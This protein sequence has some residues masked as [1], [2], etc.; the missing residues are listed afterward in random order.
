[1]RR[2]FVAAAVWAAI[3]P[4]VVYAA[5]SAGDRETARG[6]LQDADKKFAAQ[7]YRSAL[8]GYE[9][10]HAI[11]NLPSTGY[12]VAKTRAAL[13]LLVEARDMALEVTRIPAKSSEPPAFARARESAAKLADD[14]SRRV[15]SLEITLRGGPESGDVQL[16]FDGESIPVATLGSPRKTNPGHHTVTAAASGFRS[17]SAEVDVAESENKS[18]QLELTAEAKAGGEAVAAPGDAN[19][20][21]SNPPEEPKH[22]FSPLVWAGFGVGAA[23]IV[24]GSTFGI[25]HLTKTAKVKDDYCH[26]GD[27]CRDGFQSERDT[28]KTYATVA[29][30]G[31]AVGLVGVAVGVVGIFTSKPHTEETAAVAPR[32][33]ITP[34]IGPGS[35]AV[36]G[37]F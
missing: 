33:R 19:T 4:T 27:A 7:D 37:T 3:A 28:A 8:Q 29:N 25:L 36:H 31:F 5:P 21:P 20:P 16:T 1:V 12:A 26:G 15:P 9:A 18:V 11:M 24:V 35:V 2:L 6:L 22:G 14:L 32:F 34:E 13:G 30:I 10:A 23:G 17:A